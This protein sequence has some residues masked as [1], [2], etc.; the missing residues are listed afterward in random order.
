MFLHVLV[1]DFEQGAKAW[2]DAV[3]CQHPPS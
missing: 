3:F 2:L 1:S